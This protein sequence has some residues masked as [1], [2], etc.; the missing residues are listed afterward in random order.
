M[1]V[2]GAGPIGMEMTQAY[3]R[4]GSLV[5]VIGEHVLP[6]EEVEAQEVMRKVFEREGVR[7]IY[8][9]ATA[10]RRQ[11]DR[12]VVLATSGEAHSEMLLVASGRRPT[13]RGLDLE[14]A[15]VRYSESGIPVDNQ[16][17]TNVKHIFAAGDVIGI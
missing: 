14:R 9:R 7:F 5:T 17:R 8:G 3:Q 11:G 16:L 12:I 6:K 13:V 10:V 15:S 2:I 1:T 4:L